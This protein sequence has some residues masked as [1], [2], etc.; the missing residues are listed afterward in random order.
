[1]PKFSTRSK[2]RLSTCDQR[3]FDLFS[4]VV[5]HFDCTVLVGHRTEAEQDEAFRTGH[6]KLKWPKSKHNHTPSLA[7]DVAPYPIDWKDRER[8]TYF[9]G[10]V[11]GMATT[12][13][14]RIRWGGNWQMDTMLRNNTFDDLVHFEIAN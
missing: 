1:M 14:I 4:D 7:V 3:L 8:F 10:F 11:L 9:A 5:E 13:G 12:R 2:E 6:S